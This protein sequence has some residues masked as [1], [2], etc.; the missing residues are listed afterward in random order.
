MESLMIRPERLIVSVAILS[1]TYCVFAKVPDTGKITLLA[2]VVVMV[3]SP[4]PFVIILLPN[5]IDLPLLLI[6][7]PPL[8]PGNIEL[9]VN[10]ESANLEFNAVI[11]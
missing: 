6:P 11:A 5:V 1:E 7:V 4:I 8:E 2:A 3:K 9:I 10:E